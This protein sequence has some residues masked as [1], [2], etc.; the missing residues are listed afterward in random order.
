MLTFNV[1]VDVGRQRHQVQVRYDIERIQMRNYAP[2][3]R[4]CAIKLPGNV[5]KCFLQ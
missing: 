3:F 4:G 1:G 5:L 2:K